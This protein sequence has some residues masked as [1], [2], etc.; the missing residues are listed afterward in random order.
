MNSYGISAQG[1]QA[2]QLGVVAA[3]AESGESLDIVTDDGRLLSELPMDQVRVAPRTAPLPASAAARPAVGFASPAQMLLQG[4][5]P[6]AGLALTSVAEPITAPPLTPL[7]CVFGALDRG[8][9]ESDVVRRFQPQDL[10]DSPSSRDRGG[11]GEAEQRESEISLQP[12]PQCRV[13]FS[14]ADPRNS[15]LDPA[16]LCLLRGERSWIAAGEG[17]SFASTSW[18]T[19]GIPGLAVSAG[20]WHYEVQLAKFKNPQIGWADASFRFLIGAYSDTGVGDDNGS[21]AADGERCCLW[22]KGRIG[23]WRTASSGQTIG[24]AIAIDSNAQARM[25]FAVDGNWDPEP[26]FRD[27][28]FYSYMY[29]A[30]SGELDATFHCF[31][32]EMA[33]GPPDSSFRPI[34]EARIP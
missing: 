7:Q 1:Q 26:V 23:E 32:S 22:H 27:A 21:W 24:C 10:L 19:V 8:A 18:L 11:R 16:N 17:R 25:W 4:A 30:V 6:D 31:A 28:A 3:V 12:A 2:E 9:Q 34:G 29:P 33:Y 14:L 13:S 5:S 15:G 20:S